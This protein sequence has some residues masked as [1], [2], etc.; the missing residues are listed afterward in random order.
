MAKRGVGRITSGGG[1]SFAL[2]PVADLISLGAGDAGEMR[3]DVEVLTP[4]RLVRYL[5]RQVPPSF[6]VDLADAYLAA[7]VHPHPETEIAS[8]QSEEAGVSVQFVASDEFTV[9]VEVL[10]VIDPDDDLLEHDGVSL[11]VSRAAL[12][13]AS[14]ELHAAVEGFLADV[15]ALR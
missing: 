6:L 5:S 1:G 15:E 14:H 13:D 11:D 7:A 12:V 3:L 2:I 9:D 8:V 10:V 4:D